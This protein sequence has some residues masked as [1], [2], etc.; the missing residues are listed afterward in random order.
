[1]TTIILGIDP[2]LDG[3]IATYRPA[4][5]HLDVTPMPTLSI[6]TKQKAKREVD[7]YELARLIDDLMKG[8]T[9]P[10]LAVVE[11]VSASPQMG[12]TSAFSFGCSYSLVLGVLAAHFIRTELVVP[13]VWKR[14]WRIPTGSTKDVSRQTASRLMPRF[15]GLWARKK[16]DGAA[17]AA[18]LALYGHRFVLNGEREAA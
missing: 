9:V 7:R 10:C 18:L 13:A 17:E 15:A 2:G 6:G 4:L 1:M 8:A 16:D 5:D 12:V 11:R 3:A 14:A